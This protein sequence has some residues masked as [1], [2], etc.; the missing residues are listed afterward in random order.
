MMPESVLPPC[1]P[2]WLIVITGLPGSGKTT[3]ARQLARTHRLALL[4]KDDIKEPLLEVLKDDAGDSRRV[5]DAAFNV[6][7]NLAH[8]LLHAGCDLLIEGNFRA[9]GHAAALG[10][11][12][13]SRAL[14]C[15]Q[16]L[17]RLP[18]PLRQSSLAARAA[19]QHQDHDPQQQ[20]RY[21][22]ECDQFA[23]IP[24]A[25]LL[26]DATPGF[27][28]SQRQVLAHLGALLTGCVTR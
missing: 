20:A 19:V 8:Q 23:A 5:S 2:Q 21:V 3:L 13:A 7:F 6:L 1:K 9:T 14:R 24:G 28:D 10:A 26:A 17:C 27:A 22:P 4:A 25:R 12:A 11:L 18:E 15:L 16:I